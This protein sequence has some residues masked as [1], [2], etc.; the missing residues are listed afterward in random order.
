M[1]LSK[2]ASNNILLLL[3]LTVAFIGLA[4]LLYSHSLL[5]RNSSGF[6]P[7]ENILTSHESGQTNHGV[8]EN[9]MPD[10][11][12]GLVNF[13]I[14]AFI[15]FYLNRLYSFQMLKQMHSFSRSGLR[16]LA[17]GLYLIQIPGTVVYYFIH[18][19]TS[20]IYA[21]SIGIPIYYQVTAILLL[22]VPYTF[23]IFIFSRKVTKN[24]LLF[25]RTKRNDVISWLAD[26]LW[27][28]FLLLDFSG[29]YSGIITN[30]IFI[31]PAAFLGVFV[32]L[33]LRAASMPESVNDIEKHLNV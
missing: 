3:A 30:D 5:G 28:I 22:Y 25:V 23:I 1:T 18:V 11:A 13:G 9:Q 19:S 31:I 21:D 7:P 33:S 29:L 26:G 2:F 4:M 16:V 32:L 10:I 27:I 15:F 8:Y 17:N 20:N 14:C 12:F 24:H 6:S